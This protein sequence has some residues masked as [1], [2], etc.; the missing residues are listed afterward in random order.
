MLSEG[1]KHTSKITKQLI[2]KKI[3]QE[4]VGGRG[5]K[6]PKHCTHI[7]IN[8]KKDSS[9]SSLWKYCHYNTNQVAGS[10][11]DIQIA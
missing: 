7:W 2:R 6:W 1:R 11:H 4:G 3:H 5:E 8:E 10:K 9:I